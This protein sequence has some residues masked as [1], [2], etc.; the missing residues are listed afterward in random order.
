MIRFATEKDLG[1]ILEIY[2]PYIT[3]ATTSFEYEVPSL[4]EFTAMT[5]KN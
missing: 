1:R 3:E 2:G 5:G 4:E